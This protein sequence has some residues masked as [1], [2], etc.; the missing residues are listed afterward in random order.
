MQCNA[1]QCNAMQWGALFVILVISLVGHSTAV[2]HSV[3]ACAVLY[4]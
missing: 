4:M 2:A 1:M 3:V